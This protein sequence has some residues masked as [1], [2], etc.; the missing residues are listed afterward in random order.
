[1]DVNT[2]KLIHIFSAILLFG[3]GLGTAFHGLASNL[4]NDI[5]A[6]AVANRNVVLADWL[7][8][9]PTVLIQPITGLWLAHQTGWPLTTG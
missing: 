3:T 1:M 4:S 2:L 8:T 7:F 5:R 6:I 9:T